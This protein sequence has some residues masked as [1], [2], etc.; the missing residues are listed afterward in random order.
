M[1]IV[2]TQWQVA[3]YCLLY[4]GYSVALFAIGWFLA[5]GSGIV[6]QDSNY[7][8]S[9]FFFILCMMVCYGFFQTADQA[10]HPVRTAALAKMEKMKK[11]KELPKSK[12][13]TVHIEDSKQGEPR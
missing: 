13:I 4:V 1:D 6:S 2:V 7:C 11:D 8:G 10:V 5:A 9:C 12:T 3:G